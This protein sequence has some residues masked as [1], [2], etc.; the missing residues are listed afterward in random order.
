MA[1]YI[2]MHILT[3]N[4]NLADNGLAVWYK[5]SSNHV[6]HSTPIKFRFKDWFRI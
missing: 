4:T 3:F 6:V 5:T 1:F 2:G